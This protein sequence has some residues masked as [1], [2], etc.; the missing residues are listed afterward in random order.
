MATGKWIAYIIAVNT[1]FKK[2]SRG[3]VFCTYWM[4]F[5]NVTFYIV[6][7]LDNVNVTFSVRL[8]EGSDN[9]SVKSEVC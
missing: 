7:P 2:L 4:P 5:F 3:E 1:E 8:T 6:V 9:I